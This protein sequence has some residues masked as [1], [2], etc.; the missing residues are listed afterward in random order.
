MEFQELTFDFNDMVTAP[1]GEEFPRGVVEWMAGQTGLT[2]EEA[3]EELG[4]DDKDTSGFKQFMK[5]PDGVYSP[6]GH[7][8]KKME[9][10][11]YD[12]TVTSNGVIQ[13]FPVPMRNDD[14]LLF[15]GS[16]AKRIVEEIRGFW[17]RE[18]RYKEYGF[19]FKRGMLLYGP[20]GS[21][22][23]TT[24]QQVARD[25]IADGGVVLTFYPTTFLPCYRALRAIQ[26]ETPV[27]VLME[28]LDA[29]L[30]RAESNTL[31]LLDG[32]EELRKVVFLATTNY[33]SKLEPRVKNRPSRF[34]R[35]FEIDHPD[36]AGRRMYFEHLQK[37]GSVKIDI[38]RYVRASAGW[39]LSHMKEL[40]VATVI[41]GQDFNTAVSELKEMIGAEPE[42]N[43]L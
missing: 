40:F 11:M 27:V 8:V 24:L 14:I 23:S 29:L 1:N 16:K 12:A 34:D 30:K 6:V 10:G 33:L 21:G 3:L 9:P 20:P 18:E 41:V 37:S 26:P 22:K 39:P 4:P 13:F 2:F 15:P 42:G 31:N 43:Y 28:D 7:T 35:R 36:E 38:E 19:P 32:V 5:S 17:E 25:V